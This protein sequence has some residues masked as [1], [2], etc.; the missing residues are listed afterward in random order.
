M[1]EF[2]PF[3]LVIFAGVFFSMVFRRMHVPWVVALIIGGIIIGPHFLNVINV[4]PTVEFVGQMGLVFLMFMAGLETKLS[5]FR[6]FRGG[7]LWLSFINGAVPFFVGL[8]IGF[9][10]G[11][12][13]VSSLLIGIIFVSSSI[14]VV[15]PSLERHGLLQTRLGQSVVMTSIIQDVASLIMLSLLLQSIS[16]VTK[17][18]LYLFYP[19]LF[20]VLILFRLV[21]P[22]IRWFFASQIS[23][24]QDL[25]Q[26]E[27]RSVFLMLIGTVIVFELLGLH[28]IIA[29]F[30]AGLVLAES[31]TSVAFKD[32]I[33]TISYGIFIPT[34]FIIIGTQTD[35]GVF[36]AVEGTF[37][38]VS[39][40]VIGSVLSKFLSGWLGGR[41]VGFDSDQAL[42]FGVSSIPQLSTTLAVAFAALSLGYI[43]QKLITAMVILSVAT[44]LVSPTL[45]ALLATRIKG[46]IGVSSVPH[47]V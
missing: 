32:K 7:L 1:H 24:T 31:V 10:F 3:F 13:W 28:P 5:S 25:F 11:Y 23:G 29:G 9:L 19:V 16:P 39:V 46:S 21:L 37:I 47:S 8:G 26:Q 22:K 42:L 45:M 33:R 17:L 35:V 4:T 18:P 44:T 41:M 34:F 20:G 12:S 43:D 15:I 36:W 30:F 38:L 27:F 14:A 2:Y 40:I 6:E